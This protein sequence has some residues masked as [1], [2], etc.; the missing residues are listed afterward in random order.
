ML[1]L[2]APLTL[3]C[4]PSVI[5]SK[6][7]FYHRITGNYGV[8]ASGIEREDLL[9]MVTAPPELYL[10]E[11][12][13]TNLIQ[14]TQ[15]Q[16]HQEQKF[17]MINNLLNRIAIMEEAHLTY[18]DRV[19][20]SSMLQKLGI[21]DVRQFMTQV[22]K[23][24]ENIE[25][26]EQLVSLYW[27][28]LGELREMV[29]TYHSQE[30]TQKTKTEH[31]RRERLLLHEEILE[32]LQTG[33]VYQILHNFYSSQSRHSMMVTNQELRTAEQKQTAVQ[34][35][36]S[37]LKQEVQGEKVPLV[38]R[39]ENYYETSA[40][41]E[42]E[43]TE[44]KVSKQMTAAVL[45]DA[46]T[47]LYLSQFEKK[48]SQEQLWLSVTHAL[49]QSAEN[50]FYR[51]RTGW[52]SQTERKDEQY[53]ETLWQQQS[54]KQEIE[55][56]QQLLINR[57]EAKKQ[58]HTIQE[59]YGPDSEKLWEYVRE[60]AEIRYIEEGA[61]AQSEEALR[62]DEKREKATE[63][64]E[65]TEKSKEEKT[66]P[67]PAQR[68]GYKSSIEEQ[69][70]DK[71]KATISLEI[72]EKTV[73]ELSNEEAFSKNKEE[74]TSEESSAQ[75]TL[76]TL[77]R[78]EIIAYNDF[79]EQYFAWIEEEQEKFYQSI[80]QYLNIS[81]M[82]VEDV[83]RIAKEQ[84]PYKEIEE[85]KDLPSS[86]LPSD[87]VYKEQAAKAAE[88]VLLKWKDKEAEPAVTE[89][90]SLK[91]Y[92]E[93]EIYN[94]EHKPPIPDS[95]TPPSLQ[96]F[97]TEQHLSN[98]RTDIRFAQEHTNQTILQED[99]PKSQDLPLSD[100]T[101]VI[102]QQLQK[103]NQQNIAN[104]AAY[105]KMQEAQ[106]SESKHAVLAKRDMRKDS[107][108][109]LQSP[110][111]WLQEIQKAQAE[112]AQQRQKER[113]QFAQL[114]PE[115]TRQVYQRLEQYLN[116]QEKQKE[117]D[118]IS[119]NNVALLLYDIQQAE[120]ERTV[121]EQLRTEDLHQIQET[122]QEVLERWEASSAPDAL[123]YQ[124]PNAASL[125]PPLSFIHKSSDSQLY[126]EW[127]S[128]LLK[129]KQT[130][131]KTIRSAEQEEYRQETSKKTIYQQNQQL[132]EK[133]S[134]DF[135]EMIQKGVQRQIGAISEQIYSKLEKR[136]Q[137]EK[138]RRGY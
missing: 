63:E 64:Q 72:L 82:S 99:Y 110:E 45:L 62:T 33:A 86:T 23:S 70:S 37:Q 115:Q 51:L 93:R 71:E 123:A 88:T 134:M 10:E 58:L 60:Q 29:E 55:L 127:L 108:K 118:G 18:Q 2:K 54:K 3:V 76:R 90:I 27:N 92:Q 130:T 113:M 138:K 111:L 132:L 48:Q 53:F 6:E 116:A 28:H 121:R 81:Q 17:L 120:K 42:G 119:K 135:T 8:I 106:K 103:I 4:N 31:T 32:R 39:N 83:I 107:L 124:R 79:A 84:I 137:N 95:Q 136:L 47:H 52:L 14:N 30:K 40:S 16:N 26:T 22:H 41:W 68:E 104:H 24:R 5:S 78:E 80:E 101:A 77:T 131:T 66:E 34:I 56:V 1:T 49:Y 44:E 89:E 59:R 9:H 25:M 102:K 75:M 100:E 129:E 35:L 109:A 87:K 117:S 19:Y 36:L 38:Y 67:A 105:L 12:G 97:L 15:I 20:I 73:K 126:E 50:T 133:E 69:K 57:W 122:S 11:S 85:Q 7:S 43:V 74:K 61:E 114:L 125:M 98:N 46:V 96:E 91:A 112:D 94:R 128:E 65:R 21:G 13:M